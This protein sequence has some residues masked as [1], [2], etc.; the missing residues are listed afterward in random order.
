MFCIHCG[1][2]IEEG[3]RF[4]EFCGGL[5]EIAPEQ[6]TPATESQPQAVA[7]Q[8][9]AVAPQP[10]AA[11]PQPQVVYTA[12][13]QAQAVYTAQPQAQTVYTAQ[14]QASATQ[15]QYVYIQQPAP[16]MVTQPA[17][18]AVK[19]AKK[20]PPVALFVILGILLTI[21][22]IAAI[23]IAVVVFGAVQAGK[24]AKEKI[25]EYGKTQMESFM[26]ENGIV[27]VPSGEGNT[28][29]DTE[30]GNTKETTGGQDETGGQNGNGDI[31]QGLEGGGD[32]EQ[33]LEGGGDINSS[34]DHV[35][36]PQLSD[37]DWRSSADSRYS[38]P[39]V[40]WLDA[41]Q[42]QG[43]WKGMI[44]YTADG[45]EE[46]VNFDIAISTENVTLIADW[47]MV[48][49]GGNELMPEEDMADTTFTGYEY[50]NGIHVETANAVIEID[51]FWEIDGK[52]Y[53]KG[54]LKI[55]GSSDNEVYLIRP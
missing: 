34:W 52:Q 23:I 55:Q 29:K 30:S 22:I 38:N 2:P 31:E 50:G 21:G 48:H 1:K 14:P 6:T 26:D 3:D 18:K 51:E 42:Y 40:K 44:I 15:P 9:Q 17:P 12:Q 25:S 13:P 43:N 20:K 32:I 53:G 28:G 7:P 47:Y 16:Q 33:G 45:T 46:L 49:I 36:R 39:N 37:F 54:T 10:Q 19:P 35:E 27:P 5:Q 41:S 4:C 8:S 11:A 24:F